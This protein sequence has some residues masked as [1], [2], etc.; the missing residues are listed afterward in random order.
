[1]WDMRYAWNLTPKKY[2]SWKLTEVDPFPN[3]VLVG[4]SLAVGRKFFDNIGTP[5]DRFSKLLKYRRCVGGIEC[6]S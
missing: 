4:C 5:A 6:N 3:P 2:S 1:M